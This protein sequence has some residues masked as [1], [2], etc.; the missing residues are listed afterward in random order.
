MVRYE[1]WIKNSVEN[2]IAST[3]AAGLESFSYSWVCT[4]NTTQR[5]RLGK[6]R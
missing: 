1:N 2:N 6:S 5:R 3:A 4:V